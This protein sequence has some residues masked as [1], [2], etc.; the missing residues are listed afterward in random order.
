[1]CNWKPYPTSIYNLDTNVL[2]DIDFR[3]PINDSRDISGNIGLAHRVASWYRKH[4]SGCFEGLRPCL[5]M[6][7]VNHQYK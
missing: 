4:E 6:L 7:L 5:V 1:M 2:R 3:T